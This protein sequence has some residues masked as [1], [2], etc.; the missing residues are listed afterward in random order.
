MGKRGTKPQQQV[1]IIWSSEL[2]YAVGLIATDGHLSKDGRHIDLTSKDL[3]LIETFQK[4]LGLGHIKIGSKLSG[5]SKKR[6]L[7]IQFG[8]VH[9]YQWLNRIG[10]TSKKSRT[11]KSVKVP[12]RLF[13]DFV[14][15]CFDGDGTIYSFWDR[16]WADS[17]MFYIAFASGSKEFLL[18]LQKKLNALLEINGHISVSNHDTFQLRY[19]KSESLILFQFMFYVRNLPHLEG[20]FVK[21]QEIFTEHH[22]VV[23]RNKLARVVKPGKHASLRG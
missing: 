18:W 19:A 16:R 15:G 8:D 1:S 10:L 2:A 5:Y 23:R 13:P 22:N 9:F 21:A 17:F 6:Y 3:Q 7:R 4:C 20:K 11:I 12:R 14:R